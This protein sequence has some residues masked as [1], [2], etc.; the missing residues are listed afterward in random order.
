MAESEV[1]CGCADCAHGGELCPR[2]TR[3]AGA[4]VALRARLAA[5]GVRLA[6]LEAGLPTAD[7][8]T[9]LRFLVAQDFDVGRAAAMLRARLDW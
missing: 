4:I 6:E 7:D 3:S 5:E 8:Y 1:G 2:S 9:M